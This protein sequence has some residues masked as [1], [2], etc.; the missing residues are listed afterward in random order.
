MYQ[1]SIRT[2]N[3]GVIQVLCRPNAMGDGGGV[4]RS[5]QIRVTKVHAP[6]LLSL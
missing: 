6:M 5:T 1:T 2:F 4:Y 3:F